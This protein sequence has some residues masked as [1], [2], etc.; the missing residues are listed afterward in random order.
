MN[1]FK[2]LNYD[3][4]KFGYKIA[5]L[6]NINSKKELH[7]TLST[8]LQENYRLCYFIIDKKIEKQN[9]WVQEEKGWLADVKVTFTKK[10]VSEIISDIEE[11]EIYNSKV[12]TSELISLAFQSGEFSRF[13]RDTHFIN[14]EFE[15]LYLDW[16]KKSVSGEIADYVLVSK[17]NNKVAGMVT[18]KLSDPIATIG[19]IAVDEHT[20]GMGIGQK[21]LKKVEYLAFKNNCSEIKV[22]TQEMNENAMNFYL[23]SNYLISLRNLIYHFWL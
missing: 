3:T 22:S 23:K 7:S 8:L 11:I 20:R 13:K 15:C 5:E 17:V 19:L 6:I 18:L 12:L 4:E 2:H 14:N 9:C 16:I 21:L 10:I 1:K